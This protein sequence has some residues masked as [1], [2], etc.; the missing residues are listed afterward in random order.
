MMAGFGFV[1][2]FIM[3]VFWGFVIAG[4]VWLMRSLFPGASV[5]GS[6][7]KAG[8]MSAREILDQRYARGE[9][10]REHYLGMVEDLETIGK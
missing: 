10:T 8:P 9:I 4:A 7:D 2:F 1:G 5:P 6:G 3:L